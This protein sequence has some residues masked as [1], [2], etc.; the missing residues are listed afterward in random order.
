MK[1]PQIV[2]W[3]IEE[4]Y[5]DIEFDGWNIV[6]E[7]LDYSFAQELAIN[8]GLGFMESSHHFGDLPEVVLQK[9]NVNVI[10]WKYPQHPEN[11]RPDPST[12]TTMAEVI[13]DIITI[14]GEDDRANVRSKTRDQL[15]EFHFGWGQGIRN[16]YR[17]GHNEALMKTTGKENPD[18]A[19]EVI[20]EE[21]WKL[22]K[23]SKDKSSQA[24][25]YTT[26]FQWHVDKQCLEIS[27]DR[28]KSII[29]YGIDLDFAE[30]FSKELEAILI[31][32]STSYQ[33]PNVKPK[34]MQ[35]KRG[36]MIKLVKE[37]EK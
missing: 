33:H 3:Y 29:I 34:V 15:I 8:L 4:Q 21:V 25:N 22:L 19:S 28:G 6:M 30:A 13:E 5:L 26:H 20:I 2:N 18:D 35:G 24:T 10:L 16:Y 37:T 14:M 27:W 1:E 7:G 31:Q 36:V 9:P 23:A 12:M 32:K 17:L 11:R